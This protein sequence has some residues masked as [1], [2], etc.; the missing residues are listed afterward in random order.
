MAEAGECG[1]DPDTPGYERSYT[2]MQAELEAVGVP[3]PDAI[4][5]LALAEREG[6]LHLGAPRPGLNA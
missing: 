4:K 5:L 1:P 6:L 2:E 3:V